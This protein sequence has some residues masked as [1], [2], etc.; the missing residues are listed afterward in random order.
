MQKAEA[1]LSALEKALDPS[2]AYY[3]DGE[4]EELGGSKI[5]TNTTMEPTPDAESYKHALMVWRNSKSPKKVEMAKDLL[6]R[7]TTRIEYLRTVSSDASLVEAM[8]AFISV[9]ARDGSKDK[10]QK[11]QT[12]FAALRSLEEMRDLGLTPNSTTYASLIEACDA[13]VEDAQDRL[14][15]LE[16][17]FVRACDEGYVDQ[18]VLEQFKAAASTYL[19]AKI[20]V[21]PSQ[22]VEHMKVVPETWT[23]NVR[24]FSAKTKGGRKVL[25]LTIEGRFT[26]TKATAE[27][28]MR[29]LRKQ[30][31]KQM[32]QGGR[33]K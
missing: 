16:N 24:G 12:M 30:A 22:E 15:I 28:K 1:L 10:A 4:D 6:R 20:V 26:F 13:L 32:L 27:Y 19:Y 31:S 11:M 2:D 7:F 3:E 33:M 17:I 8:S 18:A 23:R 25:P 21:A 5:A 14:R 9:C 29:K